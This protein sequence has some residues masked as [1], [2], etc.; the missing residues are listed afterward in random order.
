VQ[1]VGRAAANASWEQLEEFKQQ[2]PHIQLADELFVEEGGNVIDS[3][4]GRQ[5]QRRRQSPVREGINQC[6]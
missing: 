6:G 4:L 1:W 5:Y 2:Y 3:F